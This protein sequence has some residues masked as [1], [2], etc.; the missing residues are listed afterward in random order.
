MLP[1]NPKTPIP[2]SV[3]AGDAHHGQT[4]RSAGELNSA[5][6]QGDAVSTV[7]NNP[8][9]PVIASCH[10]NLTA[11]DLSDMELWCNCDD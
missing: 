1:S 8:C 10:A 9:L 2:I 3:G 5:L 11:V 6:V 7:D 4:L